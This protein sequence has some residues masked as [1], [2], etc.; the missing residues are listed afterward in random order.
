MSEALQLSL[1]PK[2][3]EG[4]PC[5]K[6]SLGNILSRDEMNLAEFP[7]AVLSTRSNPKVKTLEFRDTQRLKSGDMI[8]R[9]WIITGAD[10]FGLPTSTDDDV[11]LG[12]MQLTMAQGFKSPKV[13]FTRYELLK[14]LQWSTEGRSYTRLTKSLDR[15]SGVRIRAANAFYD[16]KSKSFQTRNFGIIDAYEINDERGSKHINTGEPPK[17]HFIWSEVLFD[18]FK[19]G[20]IKKLNMDLYFS[21][22]SSV[23]RRLYRFLDKHF[24]YKPVLEMPLK[25]LAFEKIGLSRNYKYV[26]SIKQQLEPGLEELKEVGFILDYSFSK[27]GAQTGIKILSSTLSK[28]TKTEAKEPSPEEVKL[29]SLDPKAEPILKALCERGMHEKQARKLLGGKSSFECDKISKIIA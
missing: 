20:F 3:S 26:S 10:K 5:T 1:V 24:Y 2:D 23:S 11:I 13:Y 25:N 28:S 17:S 16:N 4:K 6:P 9:E 12:L 8:E 7:L 22:K 27:K 19:S 14:I 15:L 21:L 18:S 29:T